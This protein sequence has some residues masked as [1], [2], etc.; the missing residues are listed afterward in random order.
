VDVPG[1]V[2]FLSN[3]LA[4]VGGVV[5][6]LFVVDAVEGWRAQSEEHLRI[7]EL[8]GV[9][10][11]VVALTKITRAGP[12]RAE[13]AR[14]DLTERLAGS[15][16]EAATVVAVDAVDGVGLTEL[17][18]ALAEA[19]RATPQAA[20][21]GRPRLWVDRAFAARGAGT[22]V[23]GTLLDGSLAVDDRLVVV[24]GEGEVRIRGLQAHH[25]AVDALPAGSRAA[26]NLT[27]V[28]HHEVARGHVL[29]RAGQWHRSAVVDAS[30]RVLPS[31]GHRVSRRGA[32]VAHIGSGE[33]PTRVRL[34]GTEGLAPGAE[35]VVR[36]R[37][38]TALPLLPGDRYVL[39]ESGRAETVGGGEML[40][41]E[42]VLP[43]TRAAPN[44]SVERVVAERGW[45]EADLLERLTGE[46]RP[47]TLGR[48]VVFPNALAASREEVA[49]RVADAGALG[50]DVAGLDDRSRAVLDT[51]D[52]VEVR[53]GRARPAGSPDP[54]ADHPFLAA[55]EAAPFAPPDPE[56]VDPAELRALTQQ[57]LVVEA[58]G[59]RFA[60]SAVDRAAEITARL[61]AERPQ[62]ITLSELRVALGTTRRYAVPLAGLLDA[63]GIT[64]RRGDLRIAGPR[65]PQI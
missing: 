25:Q 52:D 45:V 13:V 20:D 5:A 2:R 36:L 9:D 49:G 40:D 37:L 11:G 21:R 65:L 7:L 62:G 14:L 53:A 27:G 3:M 57:G 50:L 54:L 23:T 63:R 6:C 56:G 51:L 41:V 38:P 59:R 55:L 22:I 32:Y 31:L 64:R 8:V 61:L 17:R 19:L 12:D 48:W 29:V 58:D 16:L 24:P 15:F 33:Y 10:H 26:L 47:P 39:R 43:A 18:A 28:A 60:A 34:L 44:R 1:H 46:R 4:G 42:P 30:L 35:G